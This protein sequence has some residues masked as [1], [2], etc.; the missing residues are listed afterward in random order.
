MLYIL[1][2]ILYAKIEWATLDGMYAHKNAMTLRIKDI[3]NN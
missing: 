3:L 2:L 1:L